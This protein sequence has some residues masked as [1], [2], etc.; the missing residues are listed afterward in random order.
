MPNHSTTFFALG[1]LLGLGLVACAPASKSGGC[2]KD[3][4]CKGD[5]ICEYGTCASPKKTSPKKISP[6]GATPA[7]APAHPVPEP[8]TTPVVGEVSGKL[9]RPPTVTD[10]PKPAEQ[11][12]VLQPVAGKKTELKFRPGTSSAK[13]EGSIVRGETHWVEFVANAEQVLNVTITSLEDNPV[14]VFTL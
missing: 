3:T 10:P 2:Q 1:L 11:Q 5:R 4:D 12:S 6:V 9:P 7:L 13:V 14:S 8:T